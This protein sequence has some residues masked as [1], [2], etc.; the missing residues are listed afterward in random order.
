[1]KAADLL[2][3][4]REQWR[5]LEL[6][7]VQL[8]R[9]RRSTPAEQVMRFSMLYRAACADLALAAAYQFPPSTVEYL[10]QLVG[11]AHNQLYRSRSLTVRSWFHELF[12][13]APRRLRADRCLWLA[14]GLFWG[15][16]LLSFG[17]TYFQAD[18]AE[19]VLGK[20]T[21][22]AVEEA[23]SRPVERNLIE[24]GDK[25][26]AMGG[27]YIFH[28]VRIGLRCFA[29]GIFLGVGG[30]FETSYNA[31]TLGAMCG[32]MAKSPYAANFFHFITAH[33]PFELTA[34]VLAA[35]AGMRLG[36]SLVDTRG[37]TRLASLR[38]A[39]REAMTTI[40]T[41]IAFFVFAAGIEAF[42]S[43]SA[44]P[45]AVKAG[46]AACSTFFLLVYFF[47]LGRSRSRG[48]VPIFAA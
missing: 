37:M 15:I 3:S 25:G 41:S 6:L 30:L 4:R 29:F 13:A 14:M 40:W 19:R 38:R 1:M 20:Q 36:F 12:V 39:G 33:S 31:A 2:E 28:N 7:C 45:Y 35:A 44:A 47:V 16:F 46:M 11:R 27:F 34:I 24:G 22:I 18:F 8:D 42:L 23:Y 26:G 17:A 10:H 5:E 48:T 21:M 43:P 32:F 9:L